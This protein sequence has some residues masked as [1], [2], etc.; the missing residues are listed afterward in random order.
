MSTRARRLFNL[1]GAEIFYSEYIQRDL[2]YCVS[3]GEDFRTPEVRPV[4][5]YPIYRERTPRGRSASSETESARADSN[6][7]T[8]ERRDLYG[9]TKGQTKRDGRT[10]TES[11]EYAC[12]EKMQ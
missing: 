7:T 12:L 11:T 8:A 2:E 4:L 10:S 1:D 6:R 5:T 9:T 3:S